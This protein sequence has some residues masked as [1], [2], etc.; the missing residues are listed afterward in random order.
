MAGA[1]TVFDEAKLALLNGTHDLD[2]NVIVINLVNN[3]LPPTAGLGTPNW[4]DFSANVVTTL[5]GATTLT[6]SL[7]EAA[8]TVIFDATTNPS[9][10]QDAGNGTDAYWGIIYDTTAAN[11]AIA[12]VELGGPIDLTAG[13]LTITW[14]AS[15]IFTLA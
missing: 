7:T 10:V 12:F 9:W 1:V 3:T 14:N 5:E 2:T 4:S 6:I 13:S 8:G 15:G 11:A